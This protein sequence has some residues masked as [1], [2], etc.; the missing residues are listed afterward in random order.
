MQTQTTNEAIEFNGWTL[1]ARPT[2]AKNPRLLLMIHG[3]TGD[4]NS[5]WVFTRRFPADYWI[6][7]P[8]APFPAKPQGF[9]WREN[10]L[11]VE[12][13]LNE[14][15]NRPNLDALRESVEALI[16]L[17]DEYAA[18]VKVEA[19]TFDAIG[20]SQGAAM[21]SVLSMLYPQRVRKAGI[22]AGFA[23]RGLEPCA[24][25]QPLKGKRLFVAHGSQDEMI[26][27]ERARDSMRLFE[28][29]GASLV[30]CE[31][32]VGHKLSANC[33]NSLERYLAD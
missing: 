33:L 31:D 8:R 16:R 6:I 25:A 10:P 20:F 12:E 15:S 2:D 7:A 27:I 19:Q 3:L 29:A 30:Y 17:T 28:R 32:A 18:S 9:S 1:R 23:P 11:S 26:P 13:A 5:M 22:L 4:E 14:Q 24:D 21:V